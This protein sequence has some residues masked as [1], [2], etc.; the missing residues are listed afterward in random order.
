LGWRQVRSR[1]H[2]PPRAGSWRRRQCR[3]GDRGCGRWLSGA[4]RTQA[5]CQIGHENGP[6]RC[7]KPSAADDNCRSVFSRARGPSDESLTRGSR[8]D[9][10]RRGLVFTGGPGFATTRMSEAYATSGSHRND[11]PGPEHFRSKVISAAL[12]RTVSTPLA[13]G[14]FRSATNCAFAQG[15]ASSVTSESTRRLGS[16]HHRMQRVFS[17]TL[18]QE[19]SAASGTK[20]AM[21]MESLHF[22]TRIGH[23]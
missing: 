21:L 20:K 7:Q 13:R 22:R 23:V 14:F 15:R 8:K 1:L 9:P 3:W 6:R 18:H 10:A 4:V 2:P 5:Q 11:T 19:S 17:G 16:H 12:W